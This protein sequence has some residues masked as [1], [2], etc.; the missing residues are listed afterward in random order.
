MSVLYMGNNLPLYKKLSDLYLASSIVGW[1]SFI[2]SLDDNIVSVDRV[3][4]GGVEVMQI[5][6]DN[7][8]HKTWFLLKYS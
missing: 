7:E 2:K 4:L 8:A 1:Y 3:K 6:F 5:E